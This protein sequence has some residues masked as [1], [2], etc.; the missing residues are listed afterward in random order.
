MAKLNPE[1][2]EALASVKSPAYI[3]LKPGET[4]KCR[5]AGTGWICSL[6]ALVLPRLARP[7]PGRQRAA[8]C[9]PFLLCW[10]STWKRKIF[11]SNFLVNR[12]RQP[13]RQTHCAVCSGRILSCAMPGADGLICLELM[14][15]HTCSLWVQWDF[16]P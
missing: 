7:H 1:R 11:W 2:T 14:T 6:D 16:A 15:S 10:G 4:V 9:T 8:G 3:L 5:K 12:H 13:S